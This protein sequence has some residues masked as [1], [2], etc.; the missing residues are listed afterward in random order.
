MYDL[1][2]SLLRILSA[3]R[4]NSH[5]L[6]EVHVAL[7]EACHLLFWIGPRGLPPEMKLCDRFIAWLKEAL[8]DLVERTE[9]PFFSPSYTHVRSSSLPAPSPERKVSDTGITSCSS[10]LDAAVLWC[11]CIGTLASSAHLRPDN[12]WYREQ[13]CRQM[14]KMSLRNRTE[15][16]QALCPFPNIEGFPWMCTQTL[17]RFFNAPGW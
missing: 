2:Y 14:E 4:M 8:A 17:D 3:Q 10:A 1:E 5:T 6:S 7:A 12:P 13:F 15:L 16:R 9:A 11:L